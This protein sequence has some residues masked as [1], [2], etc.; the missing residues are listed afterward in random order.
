MSEPHFL[1]QR[2]SL[3]AYAVG[4]TWQTD[5]Y[6]QLWPHLLCLM[7]LLVL[8]SL[9]RYS[10]AKPKH[11]DF[12]HVCPIEGHRACMQSDLVRGVHQML[13]NVDSQ[14]EQVVDA[15][16]PGRFAGSEAEPRQGMRSGHMPGSINIPFTQARII[17]ALLGCSLQALHSLSNLPP[18]MHA[19][20]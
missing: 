19:S 2:S 17:A 1:F 3:L 9:F 10:P 6:V 8:D 4:P 18:L 16:G 5:C 12:R 15:R 7:E 11:T 13:G 20:T 14:Q